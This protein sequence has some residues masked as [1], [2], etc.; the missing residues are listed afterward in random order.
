[1]ISG[2]S[3]YA[4]SVD[5]TMIYIV[6]V[7]VILLLGI[8]AAM[9]FFVFKYNRKKHPV[10]KQIEG[11]T[12]LEII[13][14]I[15]PLGLVLSMF[16]YGY[17]EFYNMRK[18][19]DSALKVK[20]TGQMWKWSYEYENGK[21]SDTLYLPL[22]ESVKLELKSVDVNHSFYIPAFRIKEDAIA[23]RVNFIILK[24]EK[25]GRYDI[26]CAEYCGLKHSYMYSNLVVMKKDDFYKWLNGEPAKKDTIPADTAKQAGGTS[27]ALF[28]Y[29]AHKGNGCTPCHTPDGLVQAGPSYLDMEAFR[30]ELMSNPSAMNL[31]GNNINVRKI[32][33]QDMGMDPGLGSFPMTGFNTR[34]SGKEIAFKHNAVI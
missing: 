6:S 33:L 25:T 18:T 4:E 28:K 31:A 9:I 14:I 32:I 29:P 16:W 24:P 22:D 15:I 19:V 11:N 30:T 13:W 26:A 2:P 1:M 10:A 21:K 3:A 8:T 34:I 17:K 12:V 7:S 20:V 5:T 27:A 23:S